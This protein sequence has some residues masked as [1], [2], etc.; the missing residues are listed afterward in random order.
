MAFEESIK[1]NSS[2]ELTNFKQKLGTNRIGLWLF[3]VSD[4]FVFGGLL[5]SRVALWGNTRP[6]LNQY[7]GLAVTFILLVSS[8]FMYRGESAMSVGDKKGFV[9]NTLVTLSLGIIF[10]I[11]VVGVEWQLAPFKASTDIYGAVFYMM[12]GMHAFHVF[13]GVIFLFVVINNGRRGIYSQERHW[14]VE[15]A[16]IYWHFV[17]VVWVFFY[18]ALYLIGNLVR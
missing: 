10:L 1:K 7:L 2:E 16:A 12:T 13:T 14:A 9:R 5:V 15:A 18:P 4:S 6:E 3:L 8:F 17:D 11:G